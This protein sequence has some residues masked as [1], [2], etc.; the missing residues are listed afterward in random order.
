MGA[1]RIAHIPEMRR[2][3]N[4]CALADAYKEAAHVLFLLN[5]GEKW[6]ASAPFR[7]TA[8]HSIELYLSAFLRGS[9]SAPEEIRSAQHDFGKLAKLVREAKLHLQNRTIEHLD[10]VAAG[11][12]YLLSRYDPKF[13]AT[14][15]PLTDFGQRWKTSRRR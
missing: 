8:L 1:W 13:S 14:M 6:P 12:E 2:R 5:E 11:R 7:L 9:G 10:A 15:S 3:R 4:E